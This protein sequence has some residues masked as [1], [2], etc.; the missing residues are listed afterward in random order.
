MA[1]AYPIL[2]DYQSLAGFGVPRKRWQIRLFGWVVHLQR[3]NY[4]WGKGVEVTNH[5]IDAS[6]GSKLKVIEVS[7]EGATSDAPAMVYYHGGAFFMTYG[8]V[9]LDNAYRY[10]TQTGCRLFIVDYRLSLSHPFPVPFNDCYD[11]LVW[12]YQHSSDLRVDRNRLAV[13]GDSAGGA[14]SASVAQR[15]QDEG[16]ISLC[17]QLL[18]YPVC[19]S[20]TKSE[21]ARQFTDTPLWTSGTNKVMWD[22]YLN[23]ADVSSPAQYA[24]PAHREILIGQPPAFV[25]TAEYDPLRDEGLAYAQALRDAGVYVEISETR[26]TVHGYDFVQC[27]ATEANLQRR[28]DAINT[29]VVGAVI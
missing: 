10:V 1:S 13:C 17:A 6:D 23:G 21:S 28:V 20:E 26:G 11:A 9:H 14:L 3:L 19:D 7:P 4:K 16:Q 12:V 18:F 5:H 2:D 22:I 8:A 24:S 15:A 25:E 29:L 27:D